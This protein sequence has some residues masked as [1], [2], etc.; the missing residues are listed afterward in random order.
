MT[1]LSPIDRP[2]RDDLAP[3]LQ[4][5]GELPDSA[6]LVPASPVGP[7]WLRSGR[8]LW[9]T[10]AVVVVVVALVGSAPYL[11]VPLHKDEAVERCQ[12]AIKEKLRPSL[13]KFGKATVTRDGSDPGLDLGSY[14]KVS[15]PV[16]VQNGSGTMVR[17]EY[18][19]TMSREPNG[20]WV[21]PTTTV[22]Y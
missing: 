11:M 8:W 12:G 20:S 22:T 16:E 7:P 15:G 21:I 14:Y 6:A 2:T 5:M 13:A 1:E 17:G 4:Q 19:C 10:A 18:L 9:I 3:V